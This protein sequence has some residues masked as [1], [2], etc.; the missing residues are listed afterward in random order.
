MPSTVPRCFSNSSLTQALANME[1]PRR[2]GFNEKGFPIRV[3]GNYFGVQLRLMEAHHYD[4]AIVGLKAGLGA[5]SALTAICHCL[6]ITAVRTRCT[7][8]GGKSG[9]K[10]LFVV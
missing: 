8:R 3:L 1:R 10:V 5:P 9:G 4:V 2:P 6:V 7:T